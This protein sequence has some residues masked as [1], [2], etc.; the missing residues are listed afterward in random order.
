MP[1]VKEAT[2]HL[3][4]LKLKHQ[5]TYYYGNR[6]D[7]WGFEEAPGQPFIRAERR[8]L[9]QWLL[10][11]VPVQWD[12]KVERVEHSDSGVAVYFSDGTSAR[13]DILVGAD[14]VHSPVRQH[15]LQKPASELLREVPLTAI[16]GELDLE[17][18]A[19]RRQLELGHSAYNLINPELGFI[20][21][22]GLHYANPDGQSGRFYWMFMQPRELAIGSEEQHWLQTASQEEKLAHVLETTSKLTNPR[23][24]EIFELTPASGIRKEA[25]VW[26]DLELDPA[27]LPSGR[28][29]LLGDAAHAMTPSKGEGAFHAF[30]DA[31]KLS[32]VLDELSRE[33]G[34]KEVETV[35]KAVGAYHTEMLARGGN[36]V[37]SSRE[38]YQ[39]A[40]R[41][42]ETGEHFIAGGIMKPI[43]EEPVVLADVVPI[44]ASKA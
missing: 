22:V 19:F 31:M 14:G 8:R 26:R 18:D 11:N 28:V 27:S 34:Y 6:Q 13:G 41:R 44:L 32:V 10:T 36:A 24:R 20:G 39:E 21:F 9:R 3:A 4:P 35:K 2:D 38:S 15:L 30:I 7:R 29:A 23:L 1:D 17:G 16:V 12:K 33:G 37:R 42:A 40:K 43:P 5:F 25:H